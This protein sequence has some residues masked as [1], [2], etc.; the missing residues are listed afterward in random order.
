MPHLG[1]RLPDNKIC[2]QGDWIQVNDNKL[3]YDV[4][5]DSKNLYDWA[6]GVIF[7][8]IL[9]IMQVSLLSPQKESKPSL[10]S[11]H[12]S[13]FWRRVTSF[14]KYSIFCFTF[15]QFTSFLLTYIDLFY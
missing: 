15:S 12:P 7:G 5:T 8:R 1:V 10:V 13:Y 4:A 6:V 3:Q 2:R 11:F 14:S 9:E